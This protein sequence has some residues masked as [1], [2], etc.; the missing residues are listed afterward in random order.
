MTRQNVKFYK[1]PSVCNSYIFQK[2]LY[3]TYNM[4]FWYANL[5]LVSFEENSDHQNITNLQTS[6][7][8]I[9]IAAEILTIDLMR[10]SAISPSA[11]SARHWLN[12]WAVKFPE[13]L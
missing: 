12:H 6:V 10:L 1:T 4:R 3:R 5:E 11:T 7:T 9:S 8:T 2:S 13:A